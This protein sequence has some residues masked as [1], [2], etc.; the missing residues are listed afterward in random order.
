M[1][2]VPGEFS[3]QRGGTLPRARPAP[4][5]NIVQN[6]AVTRGIGRFSGLRQAHVMPAMAEGLHATLHAGSILEDPRT[7]IPRSFAS[8]HEVVPDGV[9][10]KR[11]VFGNPI[12]SDRIAVLRRLHIYA[13][14]DWV[15]AAAAGVFNVSVVYDLQSIGATVFAP[16]TAGQRLVTGYQQSG[17]ATPPPLIGTDIQFP[18]ASATCGFKN[19]DVN[20]IAGGYI[21]RGVMGNP[22]GYE[23]LENF[24]VEAGPRMIVF[25]G[26]F[27]EA[28]AIDTTFHAYFNMWWD[29]YPLT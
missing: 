11:C 14:E 21:W 3:R 24:N 2:P 18:P 15:A 25:P 5:H 20:G 1:S 26:G 13:A 10:V 6:P 12:T 8:M 22:A 23:I 16:F 17:G 29:E 27:F 19:V 28:Y 9:N 7:G 4:E